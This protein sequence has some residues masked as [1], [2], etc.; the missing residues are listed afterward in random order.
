MKFISR[1]EIYALSTQAPGFIKIVCVQSQNESKGPE[2]PLNY[3]CTQ[4]F[5]ATDEW[6]SK[7]TRKCVPGV[8]PEPKH[9]HSCNL[10]AFCSHY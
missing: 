8:R 7:Q 1:R 9:T 6:C 3:R 10:H 5:L 4:D 2:E